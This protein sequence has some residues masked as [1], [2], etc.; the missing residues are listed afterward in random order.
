MGTLVRI[1]FGLFPNSTPSLFLTHFLSPSS[2]PCSMKASKTS[3]NKTYAIFSILGS[4]WIHRMWMKNDVRSCT[5]GAW[6]TVIDM[7]N[8]LLRGLCVEG[9]WMPP[10]KWVFQSCQLLSSAE[11]AS[12]SFVKHLW[13]LRISTGATPLRLSFPRALSSL[14]LPASGK[15]GPTCSLYDWT[16]WDYNRVNRCWVCPLI[17]MWTPLGTPLF[18]ALP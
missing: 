12:G 2:L 3:F 1:Q 15:K 9:N 10:S 16:H 17:T 14:S 7:V 5:C 6:C 13:Q 18:S 8:R 11:A 4:T